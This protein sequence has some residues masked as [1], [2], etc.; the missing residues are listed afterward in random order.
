MSFVAAA[1]GTIAARDSAE[2]DS[3]TFWFSDTAVTFQTPAMRRGFWARHS[4]HRGG[5]DVRRRPA[6]Q[7]T[8]SHSATHTSQ[9]CSATHSHSLSLS[10]ITELQ[11]NPQPLTQPLKHHRTAAPPTASHSASHAQSCKNVVISDLSA[12]S[13]SLNNLSVAFVVSQ[14]TLGISQ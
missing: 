10:H 1:L 14:H 2:D 3:L 4:R 5:I 12:H 9:N 8:A 7:P 13:M 11:R 6:A